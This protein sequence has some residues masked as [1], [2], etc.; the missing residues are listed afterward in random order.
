MFAGK[1]SMY[2]P[3]KRRPDEIDVSVT[4]RRLTKNGAR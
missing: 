3:E 1:D 2:D 4:R